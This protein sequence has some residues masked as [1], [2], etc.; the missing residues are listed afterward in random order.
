M[1]SQVWDDRGVDILGRHFHL[2]DI[3]I[4]VK[5]HWVMIKL[6][7]VSM[8]TKI[9]L[10]LYNFKSSKGT[11]I[12]KYQRYLVKEPPIKYNSCSYVSGMIVFLTFCLTCF[13]L[14]C[15]GTPWRKGA[16]RRC[17]LCRQSRRYSKYDLP[18]LYWRTSAWLGACWVL[19]PIPRSHN[20][21]WIDKI[22]IRFVISNYN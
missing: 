13:C 3:N 20:H 15:L 21:T 11:Y 4:E 16:A 19:Q 18:G 2:E 6:G 7:W 22:I 17:R 1:T 8:K 12:L 9:F 14:S 10:F 5:Q